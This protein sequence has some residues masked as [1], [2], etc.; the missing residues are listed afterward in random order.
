LRQWFASLDPRRCRQYILVSPVPV[1]Y[2]LAK[3]ANIASM[4][5][6]EARD[7]LLDTWTS[8]PNE[9]EWRQL[10][11]EIT[12]ASMR[13]LRGVIVSGDYHLNSLCRVTAEHDGADP[14]V[15]AYEVIA[16][17]LAA[18]SFSDWKQRIAREGWFLDTPITLDRARVYTE[19]GIAEPCPSFGGLEIDGDDMAVSIFQATE[20]GCFQQRVPLSWSEPTESV[21]ALVARSRVPIDRRVIDR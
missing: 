5:T 19:V 9:A 14:E 17:G 16:S 1:F 4:F 18:D 15:I 21:R 8:G 11:E 2:R 10:V 7:D 6:D 20:S 12:K 13:G 3:R